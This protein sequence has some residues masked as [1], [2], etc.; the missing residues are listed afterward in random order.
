MRF[1]IPASRI[2]VRVLMNLFR[3]EIFEKNRFENIA[4]PLIQRYEYPKGENCRRGVYTPLSMFDVLLF[5]DNKGK[6]LKCGKK[7]SAVQYNFTYGF[8]HRNQLV[9]VERNEG[10]S[11]CCAA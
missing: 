3:K 2:I 9:K 10:S 11:A 4:A 5:R 7:Q 6:L 8:N 1:R